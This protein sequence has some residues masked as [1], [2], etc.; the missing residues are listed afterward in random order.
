MVSKKVVAKS[1][2]F[3]FSDHFDKKEL[4]EAITRASILNTTI[5]DIPMLPQQASE[6]ETD[7]AVSSISGTASMEGSPYTEEDIRMI[8]GKN[9]GKNYSDNRKNEIKNLVN[10]YKKL[11]N[12]ENGDKPLIITEEFIKE[13]HKDITEGLSTKGN[14]PGKYRD[15]LIKVGSKE[16]GGV[17][18]PPSDISDIENLMGSFIEWINSEELLATEPFIR[19]ALAHYHL[20]L[21]HPFFAGNGRTARLLEAYILHSANIRHVSKMLSNYYYRNFDEYFKSF[22]ATKRKHKDTTPFLKFVLNAVNSCLD[23][24]KNRVYGYLYELTMKEYMNIMKTDGDLNQRQ[25]DLVSFMMEEN[26]D[27]SLASLH[28]EKPFIY[29]YKDV[30]EQTARRDLKKLS[31]MGIIRTEDKKTYRI[32]FNMLG[33]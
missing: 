21:I 16:H 2:I 12:F 5:S 27:I 10:A 22:S 29:L 8:M 32:S 33:F 28:T 11:D 3:L 13:L 17:Y 19:A 14:T 31:D 15:K 4:T 18:R 6:M 9:E 25:F 24:L 20:S 26:R 30:T 7:I 23:D 1:K